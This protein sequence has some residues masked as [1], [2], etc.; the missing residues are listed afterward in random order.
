[1]SDNATIKATD[2][3]P[4][5]VKGAFTV[6]DGEGAPYQIDRAVVAMSRCGHSQNKPFCD[7]S[8]TRIGFRNKPR[9]DAEAS[10]PQRNG[11]ARASTVPA[12]GAEGR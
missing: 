12:P 3:G 2:D 1:V 7:G 8:H 5:I 9:G 6:L 10:T 4:L 11:R